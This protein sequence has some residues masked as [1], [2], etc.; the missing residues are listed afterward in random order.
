MVF[1]IVN[2]HQK[3]A[4]CNRTTPRLWTTLLTRKRSQLDQL[5]CSHFHK[6]SH[7]TPHPDFPM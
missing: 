1:L 5:G 4:I 6:P 7:R 2:V 3:E